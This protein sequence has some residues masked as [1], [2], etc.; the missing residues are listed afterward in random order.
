MLPLIIQLPETGLVVRRV[1]RE[2]ILPSSKVL[3]STSPICRSRTITLGCFSCLHAG[4]S[5]RTLLPRDERY[6]Y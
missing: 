4:A 6:G 1:G 3:G 2:T 5:H